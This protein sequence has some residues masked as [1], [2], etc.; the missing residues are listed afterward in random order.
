M[1][2]F[3]IINKKT[4]YIFMEDSKYMKF[5]KEKENIGEYKEA[6]EYYKKAI[7]EDDNN[8]EAYFGLNLIKSY[9][10]MESDSNK[11]T[12]LLS[13]LNDILYKK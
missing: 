5:A 1:I 2:Y 9:I 8:I 4:D 6:L 3:T 12:E 13:I 10:E 7:E 11:H